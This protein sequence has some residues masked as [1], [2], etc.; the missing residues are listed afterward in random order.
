[1]D[2]FDQYIRILRDPTTSSNGFFNRV[3]GYIVADRLQDRTGLPSR[4][5]DMG[6][7]DMFVMSWAALLQQSAAQWRAYLDVLAARHPQDAR[8]QVANLHRNTVSKPGAVTAA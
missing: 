5:M 4:I 7:H 1:M 3:S 6:F 2:R 8:L